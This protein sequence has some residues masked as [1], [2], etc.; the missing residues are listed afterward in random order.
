MMSTIPRATTI[1]ARASCHL[2]PCCY[3]QLAQP[4]CTALRQK[5]FS[6]SY[7]RSNQIITSLLFA[8][9][10]ATHGHNLI[11]AYLSC[12]QHSTPTCSCPS[13]VSSADAY[14]GS[15]RYGN[16]R[17]C[18]VTFPSFSLSL[19]LLFSL[20]RARALRYAAV[21]CFFLY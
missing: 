8:L 1:T 6:S 14:L 20:S 9:N 2:T 15:P 13:R 19:L 18:A 7:Q 12:V 21:A 17:C 3:F 16:S 5:L 10:L 11:L 4:R